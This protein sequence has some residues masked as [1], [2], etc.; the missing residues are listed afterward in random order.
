MTPKAVIPDLSTVSLKP[1]NVEV[2]I[3]KSFII[4]RLETKPDLAS[5]RLTLKISTANLYKIGKNKSNREP[6]LI[7][8][9][10]EILENLTKIVNKKSITFQGDWKKGFK[11]GK[12]KFMLFMLLQIFEFL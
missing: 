1:G 7:S 10:T 8:N 5:K 3:K 2:I 9:H 4:S 6:F 11:I 12:N